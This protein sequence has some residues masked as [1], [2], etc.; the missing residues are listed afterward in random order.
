ME[1][2]N[3]KSM[4]Y[5]DGFA[6]HFYFDGYDQPSLLDDT[7]R[8]FPSKVI[9]NTE[10]C[11]GVLDVIRGPLLGSWDRAETYILSYIEASFIRAGKLLCFY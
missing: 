8:L 3:P 5:V 2:A 4:D 6:V 11:L 1:A 9:L 10:S 7:K